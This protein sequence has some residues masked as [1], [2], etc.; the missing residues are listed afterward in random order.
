MKEKKKQQIKIGEVSIV[1]Y[2]DTTLMLVTH[3]VRQIENEFRNSASLRRKKLYGVEW[4][5]IRDSIE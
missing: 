4:I 1:L 2:L 3:N 5:Q